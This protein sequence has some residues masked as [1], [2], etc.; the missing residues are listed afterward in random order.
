MEGEIKMK[1]RKMFVRILACFV[2]VAFAISAFGCATTKRVNQLE[3][4]IKMTSQK[5]DDAMAAARDAK[6]TAEGCCSKADEAAKA[7]QDAADRAEASAAKAEA[8][9]KKNLNK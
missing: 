8:I 6:S 3:E 1:N 5:A 4:Q 7:A 2:I 9:F